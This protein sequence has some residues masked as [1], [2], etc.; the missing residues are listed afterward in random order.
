MP[1]RY[2]KP[3]IRDSETI[4]GLSPMAECLFYRLL[5]TVDDFGRYDARPAMIRSACY[6]VR[7]S[8]TAAKCE[9]LLKELEQCGL[10]CIYAQDGKPFLQM[11]KWDNIPRTKESKYPAMSDACMH[12]YTDAQQVN[13]NAPLTKTETETETETKTETKTETTSRKRSPPAVVDFVLPDWVNASHWDAWHSCPKR[14]K[15]TNEQKQLSIDKLAAWKAKGVDYAAALENAAIG[16]WQGLFEPDPPTS[17][18]P[19]RSRKGQPMSDADRE[20]Y[21]AAQA[22]EARRLLFGDVQ[23]VEPTV[24][25]MPITFLGMA[26]NESE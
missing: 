1:T 25:D 16:G 26:K 10:V 11:R 4:D 24:V 12:M 3:G 14:K 6:P 15:A 9:A 5:V 17:V 19:M 7:E 23:D 8:M 20:A 22:K 18:Q 21:S 2:L 13:T